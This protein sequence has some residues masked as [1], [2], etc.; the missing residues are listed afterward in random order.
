MVSYA[1]LPIGA[2][3]T[4]AGALFFSIGSSDDAT[5]ESQ[6]EGK[7]KQ[8]AL[9]ISCNYTAEARQEF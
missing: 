8:P 4:H 6:Q 3:A 7:K 5:T 1:W 9:K 2:A